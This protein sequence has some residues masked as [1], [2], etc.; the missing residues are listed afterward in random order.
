MSAD[1]RSRHLRSTPSVLPT[2]DR[3]RH[4]RSTRSLSEKGALQFK[5]RCG[6][7][8]SRLTAIELNIDEICHSI[9]LADQTPTSLQTL[10]FQL[11][12]KFA[13]YQVLNSNFS[14]FLE[15][16]RVLPD[17]NLVQSQEFC[18]NSVRSKVDFSLDFLKKYTVLYDERIDSITRNTVVPESA[19]FGGPVRVDSV[20]IDTFKPEIPQSKSKF[21]F[22]DSNSVPMKATSHSKSLSKHSFLSDSALKNA[23]R[24]AAAKASLKYAEEEASIIK[25]QAILNASKLILNAKREMDEAKELDNLSKADDDMCDIEHDMVDINFQTACYVNDMNSRMQNDLQ[26]YEPICPPVFNC[27]NLNPIEDMNN[28]IPND[29]KRF[30]TT[31]PPVFNRTEPFNVFANEFN[32]VAVDNRNPVSTHPEGIVEPKISVAGNPGY[33]SNAS[34]DEFA[35]IFTKKELFSKV[36]RFDE[37]PENY[38]VWKASFFNMVRELRLSDDEQLEL[39]ILWLGETKSARQARNIRNACLSQPVKA[40]D[41]IWNRLDDRFSSPEII[42]SSIKKKLA[43]FPKIGR[44]WSKL[45]D[46][47]D[48]LSEVECLKTDPIYSDMLSYFD[49]SVGVNAILLKL[50][51][52]LQDRWISDAS[53]HKRLTGCV[54]PKFSYF[55]AFI[56]RMAKIKNDPCFQF[57]NDHSYVSDDVVRPGRSKL[58][59]NCQKTDISE[60]KNEDNSSTCPFHDNARHELKEC[61]I[62]LNKPFSE[63]FQFLKSN[64]YCF[65]CC[66]SKKHIKDTCKEKIKCNVCSRTDH[67]TALHRDMAEKSN[68]SKSSEG[69]PVKIAKTEINGSFVPGNSCAKIVKVKIY[70]PDDPSQTR[71]AYAMIDDQS[72]HTL[73]LSSFFDYFNLFGNIRHYTLF[74]CSGK[75]SVTGR[76]AKNFVLESLDGDTKFNIPNILECDHIPQNRQEIPSPEFASRFDHLKKICD[77][78]PPIDDEIAIEMILGR[79]IIDVH[80]VLE[81]IVGHEQGMPLAQKLPLGW[82]IVGGWCCGDIHYQSV[83]VNKINILP[84]G[85]PT[86]FEICQNKF[87]VVDS[88]D[89]CFTESLHDDLFAFS[90]QEQAFMEIMRD[91]FRLTEFG[92]WSAP[93]PFKLERGT[94]GNNR[95]LAMKRAISFDRS[96]KYDEKKSKLVFEFMHKLFENGHAESIPSDDVCNE[97]WYLP[98]FSVS[99]PKKPDAVRIVFDSSAKF[100]GICLNDV[101]LKGPSLYNSLLG[102]LLRFRREAIAIT[103][104]IEQMFFNFHVHDVHR[105]FLRFIWHENNDLKG[106]LIDYRMTVHVF[107]NSPSPAVSTYGL[108]KAVENA[109][110]DV[111][112]FV[113]KDFYVD[114][115]LTS[116]YE[117]EDA[118]NL[119]KSTQKTLRE[120]GKIRFHKICSNSRKVLE[121]LEPSELAKSI[122][123]LDL[124]SD[125]LPDQ[126]SLGLVWDLERDLLKFNVSKELRPYTKRGLLSVIN[127]IYDPIGF[128]SPVVLQG[129][130][131]MKSVLSISK[132]SSWDDPLP[133]DSYDSWQKWV[134]SLVHLENIHFH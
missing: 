17:D 126:R 114:D 41:K 22:P 72:S 77:V 129:K 38:R 97:V 80:V 30:E 50:P 35:R 7:F 71:F 34:Y 42:E 48:L 40:L 13:D 84:S 98:I 37:T 127:S 2:E 90:I 117:V 128:L 23:K 134:S 67:S 110:K 6:H 47:V 100:Q 46:L 56:E 132:I 29:M 51:Q 73:A 16:N 44:D 76:N 120:N 93:L 82:V 88:V 96:L 107:G 12:K 69:I 3:T 95:E 89:P 108:R 111:K 27:N 119:I 99:S 63:R 33:I 113:E 61:R 101:L 87:E 85:R 57:N 78:I 94:L 81:Q 66:S 74:S 54:F 112:N 28:R 18:L 83:E 49:S 133:V 24:L 122:C 102:I 53:N 116:V 70:S 20:P 4:L 15:R 65:K 52:N 21:A 91:G 62:F 104:D 31:C 1:E 125:F 75:S 26:K 59:V 92:K 64:G 8:Q 109:S 60:R 118:L 19:Q 39:L 14:S 105:N 106:P 131:I 115:A 103:G 79:D 130:M 32:P 25:Q 55:V 58:Q 68:N 123:N 43:K 11:T 86:T 121:S 5:E 9:S 10:E 124:G 45:Y 36:I